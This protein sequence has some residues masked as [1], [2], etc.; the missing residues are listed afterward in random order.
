MSIAKKFYNVEKYDLYQAGY[1]GAIKALKN[2]NKNSESEFT[3]VSTFIVLDSLY[4]Y[5]SGV[6]TPAFSEKY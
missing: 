5:Y 6:C 4:L 2:Y 3:L 1:V